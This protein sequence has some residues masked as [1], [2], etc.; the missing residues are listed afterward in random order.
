MPI[1]IIPCAAHAV[2]CEFAGPE[3]ARREAAARELG[4]A[5][6]NERPRW[7]SFE[8]RIA[9]ITAPVLSGVLGLPRSSPQP[10]SLFWTSPSQESDLSSPPVS[11]AARS[12]STA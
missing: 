6:R 9:C 4:P 10:P 2:D 12:A 3:L 8:L 7:E 1:A 11:P 5:L